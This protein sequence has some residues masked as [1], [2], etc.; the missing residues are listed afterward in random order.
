MRRQYTSTL[1]TAVSLALAVLA[2]LASAFSAQ[3]QNAGSPS[4][5]FPFVSANTTN[6][7]LISKGP[8]LLTGLMA[9][10]SGSV[11]YVKFYDLAVAPTAGAGT[12]YPVMVP[13]DGVVDVGLPE[14]LKFVNGLGFCVTGEPA[15]N[16]TTAVSSGQVTATFLFQ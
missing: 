10:N 13:S 1:N 2:W 5:G 11:A 6:C 7:T 8:H 12:P 3:A 9:G 14:P 16:D 15:N 4:S